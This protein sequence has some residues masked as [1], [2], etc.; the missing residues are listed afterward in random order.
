MYDDLNCPE[1][2]RKHPKFM[3]LSAHD[4]QIGNIWQFLKPEEFRQDD[5]QGTYAD[6]YFIPFSSYI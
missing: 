6:W 3:M 5:L 1:C 4:T 2:E